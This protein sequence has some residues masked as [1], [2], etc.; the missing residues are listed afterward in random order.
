MVGLPHATGSVVDCAFE[1]EKV[2]KVAA[3]QPSSSE[4]GHMQGVLQLFIDRGC[5]PARF[6][7]RV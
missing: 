4:Q 5:E 2:W 6:E 3:S 1:D 7:L